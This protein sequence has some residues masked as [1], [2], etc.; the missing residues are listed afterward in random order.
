MEWIIKIENKV[1]ERVLVKFN[2]KEE[3]I[4]FI[5]QFKPRNHPWVDFSEESNSIDIDLEGIQK[6]LLKTVEVMRKRLVAY[7]NVSEGFEIIKLV[8]ISEMDIE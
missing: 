7:N 6:L 3:K 5:G 8:E 4:I 2:P 1:N